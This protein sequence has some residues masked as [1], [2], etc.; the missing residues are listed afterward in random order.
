MVPPQ[1]RYQAMG[2]GLGGFV[3]VAL[4]ELGCCCLWQAVRPKKDDVTGFKKFILLKKG[5]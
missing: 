4:K 1:G 5:R 3:D 2:K